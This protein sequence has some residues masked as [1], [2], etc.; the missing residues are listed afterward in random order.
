MRQ[1][2]PSGEIGRDQ[3][4]FLAYLITLINRKMYQD[5]V[6]LHQSQLRE[7]TTTSPSGQ[8]LLQ[9]DSKY[10]IFRCKTCIERWTL[11]K[12]LQQVYIWKQQ[13]PKN[14]KENADLTPE[15][16]TSEHTFHNSL[17]ISPRTYH[18]CEHLEGSKHLIHK[19]KQRTYNTLHKT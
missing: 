17:Q 7:W 4:K 10:N 5:G 9:L 8:S 6:Q 15:L 13:D 16:W 2:Y 1:F 3:N 14:S 19:Q 11:K 12:G 18:A